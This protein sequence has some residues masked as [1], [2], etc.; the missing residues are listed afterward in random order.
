[1]R[2]FAVSVTAVKSEEEAI[3][4]HVKHDRLNFVGKSFSLVP[5]T[6]AEI[7]SGLAR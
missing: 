7:E 6:Y 5:L 4:F 3:M 2:A 1:M